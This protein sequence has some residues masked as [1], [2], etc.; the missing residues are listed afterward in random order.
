ML[1]SGWILSFGLVSAQPLSQSSFLNFKTTYWTTDDGLPGNSCVKILQDKDGFL[2]MGSFDGL[3]RFDGTRFITYNKSNLLS[4]NFALTMA[5]DNQGN[6]WVGTDHGLAHY[7]NGKITDLAD[8]THGFFIESL[9]M[10][11]KKQK[12]WIGSRNAGFFAYDIRAKKYEQIDVLQKDDIFNDILKDPDGSLW[13]AGEKNGLLNLKN[14]AWKNF[15][16]KDGLSSTEVKTLALA[17]D[18][19]MYVGTTSGLFVRK[20]GDKFVEVEKFKGIRINKVKI[21]AGGNLWIGTVYGLYIQTSENKWIYLSR[22]EGLSNNDV[23]EIYFDADSTIWLGTYRGGVNQLRPTKFSWYFGGKGLEIEAVGAICAFGENGILAGTTEG[24]L[25]TINNYEVKKYPIKTSIKQRI[26]SL[27]RDDKKNI[28]VACYDGL[29]LLTPD[30]REKL[31]TEKDGLLT[32]QIRVIYQDKKGIY[33]IGTRNAGLIRMTFDVKKSKPTF[34]QFRHEHLNKVNSTFIM[35]LREDAQGNLLICSNNGGLT[36]MPED[37]PLINYSKKDGLQSNTCFSVRSDKTGVLWLTTTDG[38]TRLKDGKL[39][40]FTRK[41]GM[42]HENPMDVMEDSL[43]FLWMPTQ[44]GNIRVSKQQLN[45]YADNE[46]DTIE[47]KLFDKNN[48]L[49]KSECTG[50]ARAFKDNRGV[51]WFPMVGGLISVDP[52]TIQISKKIPSIYIER[53]S[54]DDVE[55]PFD[56]PVVV[57]STDQR[58]AFEFIALTLRYPNSARYQYQ[59]KPFDEGWI[60]AGTSRNAVYTNLPAGDYTFSVIGCNNDGVWSLEGTSIAVV[61]NPRFYQTWWFITF[62]VSAIGLMILGYVRFR[63]RSIKERARY[64]AQLVNERTKMIAQQRDELALLNQEL[65]SSQEEVMAQR[66]SLAEKI[67]ELAEK[68]VEIESMNENLEKIVEDRTRVLNEQSK[69]IS[70]YIFINA[71]K[72]RAPVASILGLINLLNHE[73]LNAAQKRISDH[74]LESAAA[75]D[76]V[77]R[78]ISRMLEEEFPDEKEKNDDKPDEPKTDLS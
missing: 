62:V 64:L 2:W 24:E 58:V 16:E 1:I 18:G 77:I 5:S 32:K 46:A 23:R 27:L 54:V 50:T 37:G 30:G 10:D 57:S 4:S 67:E 75:L 31:F 61:V 40:T 49:I 47:W 48:D 3:V 22:E 39:F 78:S 38:V 6:L 60:N 52:L 33:W 17:V 35:D 13:I 20:P 9:L 19:T 45:E 34:E 65:Q 42:P 21:D 74:L 71:H 51:L 29:L 56:K 73:T 41:D 44:K 43:G 8:S 25:Y 68:N 11:E 12:V 66:D 15:A 76:K 72:L 59:L 70:N 7:Y 69:R 26:Y 28:W 14:G 36:I 55:K 53:V 63:T